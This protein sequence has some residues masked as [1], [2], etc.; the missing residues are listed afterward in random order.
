MSLLI[1]FP[2]L[3]IIWSSSPY[4]TAQI[5][6]ELKANQEEPDLGTAMDKGVNKSVVTEDGGP[7]SLND[8]PIDFIQNIPGINHINYYLIIQKVKNI[9]QLV[10]L[11]KEQFISLIGEEN[12]RKAYNFINNQ[13]R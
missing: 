13:V 6:L 1:S 12:G 9:E 2:K 10:Q 7:P 4:E 3:K 11:S 5:F 8:D